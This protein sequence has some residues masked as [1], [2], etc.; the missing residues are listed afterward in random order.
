MD[1]SKAAAHTAHQYAQ[2]LHP[3]KLCTTCR[4]LGGA[5]DLPQA[6]DLL[7]GPAPAPALALGSV[8]LGR[9][10][11][12]LTSFKGRGPSSRRE[13][14]NSEKIAVQQVCIRYCLE[15]EAGR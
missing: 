3:W 15:E 11:V 14:F 12:N 4:Q 2:Q 6:A 8:T 1:V 5:E 13:S 10:L 9:S 7:R